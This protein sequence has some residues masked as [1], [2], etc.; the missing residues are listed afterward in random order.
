MIPIPAATPSPAPYDSSGL[1]C[2][3][4]RKNGSTQLS[5]SRAGAGSRGGAGNG[6]QQSAGD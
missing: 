3:C 5:V 4:L 2:G 6:L 1:R